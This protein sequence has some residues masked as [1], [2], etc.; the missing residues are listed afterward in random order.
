[1]KKTLARVFGVFVVLIC[2]AAGRT[3]H[4]EDDWDRPIKGNPDFAN[5]RA[6]LQVLVNVF[7]GQEINHFCIV[8][9]HTR[10]MRRRWCI[11]LININ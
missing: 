11:G 5:V 4:A 2:C 3:A 9:N 1:M 6:E 8:A 7:A 10:P